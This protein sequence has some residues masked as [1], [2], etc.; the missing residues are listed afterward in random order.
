MCFVSSFSNTMYDW[1]GLMQFQ[2]N[3]SPK[4]H[5]V[6]FQKIKNQIR[7][8]NS[9]L[10]VQRYEELMRLKDYLDYGIRTQ[11]YEANLAVANGNAEELRSKYVKAK[12]D[13]F[14][15]AEKSRAEQEKWGWSPLYC[16]FKEWPLPNFPKPPWVHTQNEWVEIEKTLLENVS[17]EPLSLELEC[18][19]IVRAFLVFFRMLHGYT[20]PLPHLD[21]CLTLDYILDFAV[22]NEKFVALTNVMHNIATTGWVLFLGIQYVVDNYSNLHSDTVALLGYKPKKQVVVVEKIRTCI[23]RVAHRVVSDMVRMQ[24]SFELEDMWFAKNI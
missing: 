18:S 20:R 2:N 3:R 16:I 6:V 23:G 8:F 13:K 21:A 19:H 12:L 7:C 14:D 11:K 24:R 10:D 4:E 22:D 15:D 17:S 5:M 1:T 9:T